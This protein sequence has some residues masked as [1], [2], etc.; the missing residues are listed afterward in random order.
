MHFSLCRN[1]DAFT[2]CVELRP[3]GTTE[4][5]EHILRAQLHPA[6]L[7]RGVDLRALDDDRMRWKIDTPSKRRCTDQNLDVA[8]RKEVFHIRSVS[9]AHTGVMDTEA[10]RQNVLEIGV[11]G[12]VC[13]LAQNLAG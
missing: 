11:V 5:L 10:I 6:T 3:T 1:D 12:R 8:I 13:C 7:L 9:T 4:H 2:V